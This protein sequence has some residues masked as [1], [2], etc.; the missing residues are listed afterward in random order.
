MQALGAFS[1][2]LCLYGIRELAY[3]VT[4]WSRPMRAKYLG[5]SR[6]IRVV[7]SGLDW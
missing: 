7:H 6:P 4:P 3:V 1:L 2:E 5:G